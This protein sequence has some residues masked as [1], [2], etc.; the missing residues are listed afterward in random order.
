MSDSDFKEIV[1]YEIRENR[2]AIKKLE[3]QVFSNKI[4]LG[5]FVTGIS[6]FSS[7]IMPTIISKVKAFFT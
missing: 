4:K 2:K 7:T 5:M 1:L 6:L 3:L